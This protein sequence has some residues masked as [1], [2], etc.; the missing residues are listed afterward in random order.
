MRKRQLLLVLVFAV[1][2]GSTAFAQTDKYE[3]STLEVSGRGEVKIKPDVAYLTLA[4]ETTSKTAS[5]AVKSNSEKMNGVIN[6]LKSLIGKDDKISTTGYQLSPIYEYD[7]KTRRSVL[8]GYR[9]SNQV[10]VEIK[11]LDDLGK[12]IDSTTE[13]GANRIDSI[14]F[15]TDKREEYRR[16]ALVQAVEDAR[17][18]AETVSKAA[19]VK[20]LRILRISPSYEAP[21][22]VYRDFVQA[23]VA[24]E[25]SPTPIEPGELTVSANVSIVF[26]IE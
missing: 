16:E 20:I 9:A 8:T 14:S 5:E 3:K 1:L 23:K 26:E 4:V 13:V 19:G 21:I 18:T 17:A 6:K 10:V 11:N 24:A 12:L 2:A 22:P 7:E 15:G 25:A